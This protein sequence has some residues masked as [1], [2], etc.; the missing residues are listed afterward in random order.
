M[1]TI[2]L[3]LKTPSTPNFI[4]LELPDNIGRRQDGFKEATT[5]SIADLSDYQ[6]SSIADA[7]KKELLEKAK[8]KR[9]LK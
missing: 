7:W 5:I 4:Q 3:K 9:G 6:L 8:A 2:E 1:S